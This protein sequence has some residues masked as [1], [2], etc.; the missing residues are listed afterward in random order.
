[1]TEVEVEEME[2]EMEMETLKSIWPIYAYEEIVIHRGPRKIT[3][4]ALPQR[5]SVLVDRFSSLSSWLSP[6]S[7]HIELQYE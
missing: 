3:L 5:I 2:M 1:M 7:T 6:R 4:S